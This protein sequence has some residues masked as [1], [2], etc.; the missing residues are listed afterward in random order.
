[1]SG[2]KSLA[3]DTAIYGLSSI[4]GRFLNWCFVFLYINVLKTT[5]EYGI[6]TNLYAYMALLLI[7]LT[8]GLETGF[9]RFANDETYK[10]PTKVY[11]TGLISLACTSSLFFILILI[12]LQPISRWLG[13]PEHTDYIWMMALII[14]IDAFTALP[15]AY[16][17]YQKRP[18]RFATVKLLSIFINIFFNLFFILLCPW[19]YQHHPAAVSWFFE[20]TFMVGYI[21]VSNII[22]SSIILVILLPEIFGVRYR[23]D[24]K[25]WKQMLGYSFPLLILGVAGIMNQTFDKMLYPIL[26]ANRPDPMSELGIYGAVYKISIVM[27]MFT[28]AFRFAYEPFIFA[29]NKEKNTDDNKQAYADAMKYFIIFGLL[30]FLG[31]MF[32][33]DLVQFFMPAQYYVGI[34]VVPIVMM[35]QLFFG[36]FFNLSL[37]YKLTDKTQWGAWFSLFGFIITIIINVVFVPQYGYMACAWAAFVCYLCMMLASYFIGQHNYPIN[38]D[39]KSIALYTALAGILYLINNTITIDNLILRLLFRT[40]LLAIFIICFILRDL[41]LKEIPII[42]RWIKR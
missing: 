32:Y 28:Q 25:I 4:V 22:S 27:L 12:F 24:T 8:Y 41:P 21:L 39:L 20:P 36:I 38:Y 26:A 1:M 17:R 3:K 11:T 37:W 9:F 40:I 30:I 16:L 6:V 15:F 10:D 33:I 13:Y 42:N 2:M 18:I 35:G 5:A 34:D 7:I 14:A 29:K 19:L 31:V 23:F